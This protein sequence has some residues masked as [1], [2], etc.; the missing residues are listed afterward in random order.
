[1]NEQTIVQ[2]SREQEEQPQKRGWRLKKCASLHRR[3][4]AK[5]RAVVF[6]RRLQP[7]CRSV[8]KCAWCTVTWEQC[9]D[10]RRL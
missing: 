7:R 8:R 4:K 9:F 6:W 5:S 3:R 1:M 2:N 10:Y